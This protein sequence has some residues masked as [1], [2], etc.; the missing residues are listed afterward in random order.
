M[1]LKIKQKYVDGKVMYGVINE[2]L[3]EVIP[4]SYDDIVDNNVCICYKDDCPTIYD[5]FGNKLVEF[6]KKYYINDFILRS[7]DHLICSVTDENKQLG[8]IEVT[9]N[10]KEHKK[11]TKAIKTKVKVL[12]EFGKADY[13][14]KNYSE[15]IIDH[16]EYCRPFYYKMTGSLSYD[17][18]RDKVVILKPC[19][20]I[21]TFS[22]QIG[23]SYKYP[24][25]TILTGTR[26]NEKTGHLEKFI[27][28]E[29]DGEFEDLESEISPDS[30]ITF[31]T[32]YYDEYD[33]SRKFFNRIIVIGNTING[34]CYN[35]KEK[36]L[37]RAFSETYDSIKWDKYSFDEMWEV[38]KNGK[39]GVIRAHTY[40]M[41]NHDGSCNV[42]IMGD[43]YIYQ[44]W[45]P[46]KY[47]QLDF[48][49]GWCRSIGTHEKYKDLI[50][51][52]KNEKYFEKN[53]YIRT[54]DN[55]YID[56]EYWGDFYVCRKEDGKK[57]VISEK[58]LSKY[59]DGQG[60]VDFGHIIDNDVD[61]VEKIS[62]LDR[63]YVIKTTKNGKIKLFER[64]G[65]EFNFRNSGEIGDEITSVK[66]END[67]LT[68]FFN[69]GLILTYCMSYGY[70]SLLNRMNSK[71]ISPNNIHFEYHNNS[72]LLIE[73]NNG[74]KL[75]FASLTSEAGNSKLQ[76]L[77]NKDLTDIRLKDTFISGA[78]AELAYTEQKDD[79][80][81]TT[82][83]KTITKYHPERCVV[84]EKYFEGELKIESE[85]KNDCIILS[86]VDLKT[87]Q[88]VYGVFSYISGHILIDF[89]FAKI[90]FSKQNY[91]E[92]T[93]FDGKKFNIDTDGFVVINDKEKEND[94]QGKARTRN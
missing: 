22:L 42:P 6:D 43:D 2:N 29:A 16:L 77:F 76:F 37:C 41:S 52:D 93:T 81:L 83:S 66:Q 60:F 26:I 28:Q 79:R 11:V 86:K 85:I 87:N 31:F 84:E 8:I 5:R 69:N 59:V 15:F 73:R 40:E 13:I 18:K 33:G 9:T 14:K 4:F 30:E 19:M 58:N 7:S 64:S 47:N 38:S 70:I 80:K 24:K 39:H 56:I 49:L 21:D 75:H 35:L 23:P 48:R 55:N 46:I 91:F 90:R 61:D 89:Q 92:C 67:V 88:K 45:I 63:T 17:E 51:F 20:N 65:R 25:V 72:N 71:K 27:A 54:Y 57:D 78:D 44:E 1:E 53:K 74:V 32:Y 36:K 34:Y 94:N 62:Y 3:E 82:L 12:W 68:V 50:I 10:V